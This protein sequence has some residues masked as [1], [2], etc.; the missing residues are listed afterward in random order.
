M[1]RN[2]LPSEEVLIPLAQGDAAIIPVRERP[3]R[4]SR[5][6]S[7]AIVRHGVAEIRRGARRTLGVIFHDAA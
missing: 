7:K 4:S 6:W 3:I 2:G 5:G 1:P